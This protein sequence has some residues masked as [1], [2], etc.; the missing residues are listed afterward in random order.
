MNLFSSFQRSSGFFELRRVAAL[1]LVLISFFAL[2]TSAQEA[3][4]TE[5]AIALFN[6]G[7]DEHS[8]GN[9][10]EAI[11]S[12]KAAIA[13]FEKFPEAEFQLA[14]AY[15][16]TGEKELAERSFKKAVDLREDWSLA[17]AG[18]GTFLVD[19]DRYSEAEPHL[20]KAI[21]LDQQN[22]PAFAALSELRI[23]TNADA[24]ELRSLYATVAELS[25]KVRPPFNLDRQRFF[26]TCPR[27]TK[28]CRVK[29][30]ASDGNGF[31]KCCRS[32]GTCID[33]TR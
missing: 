33:L 26:R 29:L 19:Q 10:S 13:I 22:F 8:K 30:C 27:R 2:S 5:R 25:Q 9:I 23:R 1:C 18:L 24:K 32:E 21:E 17:R 20:L 6:K 14:T 11:G 7:Q 15:R 31:A 12:Y 16:Q 28:G 4:E 3:E